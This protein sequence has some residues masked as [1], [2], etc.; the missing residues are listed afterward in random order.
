[1]KKASRVALIISSILLGTDIVY[2]WN[3]LE[4][5]NIL[6][7]LGL[8]VF[9]P[10]VL[11]ALMIASIIAEMKFRELKYQGMIT[12]ILGIGIVFAAYVV[13]NKN[14][15]FM[16]E[17]MENS[18][19]LTKSSNLSVTNITM[20]S[21]YSSYIFLFIVLFILIMGFN[22]LFNTIRERK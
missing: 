4:S 22:I 1:M 11:I 15:Q 13:M 17:I 9:I 12:C 2:V 7:F 14:K 19:Q 5:I 8:I 10:C 16:E 18:R 20:S 6:H 3:Y 21:S